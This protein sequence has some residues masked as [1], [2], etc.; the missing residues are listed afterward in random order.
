MSLIHVNDQNFAEIE[1]SQTPVL[2]DFFATWCGPC[3]MIA[4]I[5]EEIAAEHPEFTIAK[6][7]VDGAPSLAAAFGIE[8]IPTLIILKDGKAV[9]RAVGAMPKGEI[10][11]LLEEA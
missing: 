5:L 6:I 11:K 1:K 8:S 9:R 2:V 10:L 3:R 7:D 4:P